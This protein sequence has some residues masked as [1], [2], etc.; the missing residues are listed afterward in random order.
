MDGDLNVIDKK[1]LGKDFIKKQKNRVSSYRAKITQNNRIQYVE[2]TKTTKLE[3]FVLL[4][5]DT[6][7][8]DVSLDEM[9][10][11]F[12]FL[13]DLED[14]E[15]DN[16]EDDSGT[17]IEIDNNKVIKAW[18]EK[19]VPETEESLVDFY[20][21]DDDIDY[22]TDD[23]EDPYFNNI[24]KDKKDK[25][26]NIRLEEIIPT[27]EN[28]YFRSKK[29]IYD[30]F[31]FSENKGEMSKCVFGEGK[32]L[33]ESTLVINKA[34]NFDKNKEN[35]TKRDMSFE[36]GK[37]VN[38]SQYVNENEI[39]MVTEDISTSMPIKEVYIDKDLDL[40][41][42]INYD[43]KKRLKNIVP[44][45]ALLPGLRYQKE[46]LN[47]TSTKEKQQFKFSPHVKTLVLPRIESFKS[48]LNLDY[49]EEC[50]YEIV[51]T[52]NRLI[53]LVEREIMQVP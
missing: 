50:D 39:L 7:L 9:D 20:R 40:E 53:D 45:N 52:P 49:V 6:E 48:F 46:I 11:D 43:D 29:V 33:E 36:D 4:Q 32:E 51:D 21:T 28:Q 19:Y 31:R 25:S 24:T 3:R 5:E 26:Q 34:L 17:E 27:E 8:E 35:L 44:I 16:E 30:Y 23:T 38:I 13:E 47:T 14:L 15:E 18:Q 1:E 22:D 2:V 10:F 12:D 42:E 41:I 37:T